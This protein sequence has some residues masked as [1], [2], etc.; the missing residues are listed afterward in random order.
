MLKK[1]D[2]FFNIGIGDF[3][4]TTRNA[5]QFK[6]IAIVR[7]HFVNFNRVASTGNNLD[8]I[9]VHRRIRNINFRFELVFLLSRVPYF[10]YETQ[11]GLQQ[12]SSYLESTLHTS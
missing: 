10:V 6:N 3:I 11:I 9:F 4:F 7:C 2:R 5:M 12:I 1:N 8:L